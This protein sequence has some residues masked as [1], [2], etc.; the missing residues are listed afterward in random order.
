MQGN[1]VSSQ[2]YGDETILTSGLSIT[3]DS[4]TKKTAD[5]RVV[6]D[7]TCHNLSGTHQTNF[8]TTPSHPDPPTTSA[9]LQNQAKRDNQC[10]IRLLLMT[11]QPPSLRECPCDP[12]PIH[13][14]GVP[15]LFGVSG[16]PPQPFHAQVFSHSAFIR[17]LLARGSPVEEMNAG[18]ELIL[19]YAMVDRTLWAFK[20]LH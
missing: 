13:S 17:F 7:P 6:L 19:Q 14:V 11:A 15:R 12:S 8:T 4:R 10:T 20:P 16:R 9:P 1:A 18:T 3:T 2:A 5:Q